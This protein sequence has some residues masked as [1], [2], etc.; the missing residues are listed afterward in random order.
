[1]SFVYSE[2]SSNNLLIWEVF[3]G[4]NISEFDDYVSVTKQILD[5]SSQVDEQGVIRLFNDF[6]FLVNSLNIEELAIFAKESGFCKDGFDFLN[7]KVSI[8]L[9]GYDFFLRVKAGDYCGL[10]MCRAF[11]VPMRKIFY[12]VIGGFDAWCINHNK[13]GV[14]YLCDYS[15]E[16]FMNFFRPSICIGEAFKENWK[17]A[18]SDEDLTE[19]SIPLSEVDFL[20]IGNICQGDFLI[21]KKLGIFWVYRIYRNP[22]G[23][24]NLDAMFKEQHRAMLLME[25][26]D[27]IRGL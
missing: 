15:D 22:L 25:G 7:M 13:E 2:H 18:A 8:V 20:D 5:F 27:L 24:I 26:S 21:H 14:A 10:E 16:K 1:M 12:E 4:K 19:S 9:Y 3:N 23:K 6:E 11:S 17:C